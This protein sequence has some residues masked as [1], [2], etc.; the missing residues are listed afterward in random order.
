MEINPVR[1]ERIYNDKL[2]RYDEPIGEQIWGVRLG[3]VT[4]VTRLHE[5]TIEHRPGGSM[6]RESSSSI[7]ASISGPIGAMPIGEFSNPDK[8]AKRVLEFCQ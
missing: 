7:G 4:Y 6:E 5:W 1:I 3:A 8:R 2:G